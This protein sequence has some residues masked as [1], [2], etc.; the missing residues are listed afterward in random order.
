MLL[1]EERHIFFLSSDFKEIRTVYFCSKGLVSL[2]YLNVGRK[3]NQ[4]FTQ[5]KRALYFAPASLSLANIFCTLT[6]RL[7]SYRQHSPRFTLVTN[8]LTL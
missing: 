4:Y 3:T 1:K 6:I 2:S 8:S 7:T 5:F